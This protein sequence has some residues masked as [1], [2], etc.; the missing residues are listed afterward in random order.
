L[1]VEAFVVNSRAP[2][3]SR[4]IE[5]LSSDTSERNDQRNRDDT[6]KLPS[7]WIS[8]PVSRLYS[9]AISRLLAVSTTFLYCTEMRIFSRIGVI[10]PGELAWLTIS[11]ADLNTEVLVVNRMD[12]EII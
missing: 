1:V 9:I 4:A 10:P 3:F 11:I 8:S 6:V 7:V 5:S 2:P 12:W